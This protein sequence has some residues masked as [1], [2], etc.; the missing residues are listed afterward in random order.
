M[1]R[2][3]RPH[4]PGKACQG[5]EPVVMYPVGVLHASGHLAFLHART[6]ARIGQQTPA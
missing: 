4:R 2:R 5:D 1:L 3:P 6:P